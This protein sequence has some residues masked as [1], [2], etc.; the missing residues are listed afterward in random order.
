M[1]RVQ[2][3]K[4]FLHWLFV[5]VL[6]AQVTLASADAH[7]LHEE[8]SGMLGAHE[9]SNSVDHIR[10]FSDSESAKTCNNQ[11]AQID[12]GHAHV[13]ASSF[14]AITPTVDVSTPEH[15]VPLPVVSKSPLQVGIHTLPFRPPI[16]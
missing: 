3:T 10:S 16:S 2:N 9:H 4:F 15:H 8:D 13:H 6:T 7:Q 14:S 1:Q 11:L 5:F 12:C